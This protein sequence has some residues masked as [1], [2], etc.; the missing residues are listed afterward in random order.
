MEFGD[1]LT[2]AHI[3]SDAK[4]LISIERNNDDNSAQV[5]R[6][7]L[8]ENSRYQTKHDFLLR[9]LAKLCPLYTN[10]SRLPAAA[11]GTE[12]RLSHDLALSDLSTWITSPLRERSVMDKSSRHWPNNACGVRVCPEARV[13]VYSLRS[14]A[15][16]IPPTEPPV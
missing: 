16:E 10:M 2:K 14:L 13:F 3:S 4:F 12:P 11:V 9:I 15:M 7:R 5:W 6:S 8:T 1:K